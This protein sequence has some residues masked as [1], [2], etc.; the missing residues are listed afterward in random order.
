MKTHHYIA[1]CTLLRKYLYF[2]SILVISCIAMFCID[3]I[4]PVY[5]T[6]GIKIKTSA[7]RA[8]DTSL[9]EFFITDTIKLSIELPVPKYIDSLYYEILLDTSINYSISKYKKITDSLITD[10]NLITSKNSFQLSIDTP[11]T[12]KF[13]AYGY[14]SFLGDVKDSLILHFLKDSSGNTPPII[15][16]KPYRNYASPSIPCSLKIGTIKNEKWQT[17]VF[18]IP[19]SSTDSIIFIGD[20]LGIWKPSSSDTTGQKILRIIATDNSIVQKSSVDSATITLVPDNTTLLPPENVRIIKSIQDSII[21]IWDMDSLADGY[22]VLRSKTLL[23][24]SVDTFYTTTTIFGIQTDSIYFY[25]VTTDNLFGSSTPSKTIHAANI[26]HSQHQI[27]FDAVQSFASEDSSNHTISISV[28]SEAKLPISVYFSTSGWHSDSAKISLDDS[29]A[30]IESGDKSYDINFII[31]DDD[32]VNVPETLIVFIDSVSSGIITNDSLH[33]IIL[34]DNDTLSVETDSLPPEIILLSPEKDSAVVNSSSAIITVV[35]TDAS[36]ITIVTAFQNE[37]EL[38]V[39]SK[40]SAYSFTLNEL[41]KEKYTTA[42]IV[43]VD[44]SDNRNSDTIRVT[45]YYKE[46]PKPDLTI[47][48]IAMIPENPTSGDTIT[49]SVTVKNAGGAMAAASKLAV[50]VGGETIPKLIDIPRIGVGGIHI[51]VRKELLTV[52]QGYITSVF[53]DSGNTVSESDETNNG[54]EISF[55][56]ITAQQPD[57]IIDTITLTPV[58][59]NTDDTITFYVTV[60]NAGGAIAAA[61]KLAVRVGGETIPKLI[62]IP[63]IGVGG[64]H[65][66]V[67]KELLTVAQRY[68]ISAIADA[69]KVVSESDE[70]NNT[71][72]HTVTVTQADLIVSSFVMDPKNPTTRDLITFT[73]TIK[74]KGKGRAHASQTA[75][76]IGSGSPVLL[77]TPALNTGESISVSHKVSLKNPINYVAYATADSDK[78]VTESDESNNNSPE[79]G[80]N[81]KIAMIANYPR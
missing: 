15:T 2:F 48:S 6:N 59:P 42:M 1:I 39:S 80:F 69:E 36:G 33:T 76:R 8:V 61:S 45:V 74:N 43:A 51:A 12:I 32:K 72:E 46:T 53:A 16:L 41:E 18:S 65:W 34:I 23:F 47:S 81:V 13:T 75:I 5:Y 3:N 44:A 40:D 28:S 11:G 79:L 66:A 10:K 21:L 24:N 7:D 71:S 14:S 54:S 62:D 77:S 30:I 4:K 55:N 17:V 37:A 26:I 73:V 57:L 38:S 52:A 9:Y 19:D 49:F 68:I 35:A 22:S 50:R 58:N 63:R 78:R 31:N 64:I 60:K 20:S 29:I 25:K 27:R 56:V 67:R 70:T